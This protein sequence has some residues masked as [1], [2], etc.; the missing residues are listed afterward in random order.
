MRVLVSG[1]TGMVGSHF[2][3][4]FREQGHD[5]IVLL[6]EKSI[7]A[8]PL[9]ICNGEAVQIRWVLDALVDIADVHTEVIEDVFADWESRI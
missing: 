6:F 9:N 4:I 5:V 7:P 1:G 3:R 2:M 8:A